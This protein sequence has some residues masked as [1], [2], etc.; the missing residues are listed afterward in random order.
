LIVFWA[1][2]RPSERTR[3]APATTPSKLAQAAL[4]RTAPPRNAD[5]W[6]TSAGDYANTR[7]SALADI[8]PANVKGLKLAWRFDT[9]IARGHEAGSTP[10][11]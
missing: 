1:C 11:I 6:P 7:F 10:L 4:V 3:P 9:E 5:D 8:T 2:H